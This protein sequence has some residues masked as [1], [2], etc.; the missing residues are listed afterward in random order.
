MAKKHTHE[1]FI[2]AVYTLAGDEY[3]VLGE[4]VNV[5][6][7]LLMRHNKCRHEYMVTPYK[8]K[9][10][11]RC[12]KCAGNQKKTHEQY[13][14]EFKKQSKGEY[15]LLGR[16]DGMN[17]KTKIRHGLCG[18]EYYV[19][20]DDFK[21]G[22]RCP[23]CA[24][25]SRPRKTQGQFEKEVKEQG[26]GEYEVLSRYV[27]DDVHIT[28]KHITC[29]NKYKVVPTSFLMG[30]RCPECAKTIRADKQR[31]TQEEFERIVYEQTAGEYTV[32]GKYI[33]SSDKIKMRHNACDNIYKV[34][35]NEFVQGKRCPNCL[36]SR[37]EKAIQNFLEKNRVEYIPQYRIDEC[38]YK[39]PLPF[40]FAIFENNRLVCLVEYD[41]EQHFIQKEFFGGEKE[42]KK[43]QKRD[44]IK[45]NYCKTAKIPL[46]EIPYTVK[47]IEK[48]LNQKLKHY[49]NL[50][51]SVMETS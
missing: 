7:K 6:T 50:E 32:L 11:R 20:P 9:T 29:G 36:F 26:N 4:Y 2:N 22:K 33:R 24:K 23:E 28:L 45:R 15:T 17:T 34:V 38:R 30:R 40:D 3:T 47:D 21:R 48:H 41:G 19:R 27:R 1:D 18:H 12:P 10:G 16:Y 46:I 49:A 42:F 8:F 14:K 51:P 13:L 25:L 43:V 35:A 5:D 44:S 37:G 39:K 31:R